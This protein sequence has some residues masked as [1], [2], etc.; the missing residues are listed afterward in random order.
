M[1]VNSS[2]VVV[3]VK[4]LV[5][6]KC[7]ILVNV[8]IFV[9]FLILVFFELFKKFFGFVVYS[10]ICVFSSGFFGLWIDILIGMLLCS[11]VLVEEF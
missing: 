10:K 11:N 3:Y 7:F 6:K 9:G 1:F 4:C 5:D 8:L 2:F